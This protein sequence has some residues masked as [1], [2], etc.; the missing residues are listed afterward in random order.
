MG[1]FQSRANKCETSPD[2][3]KKFYIADINKTDS[4]DMEEFENL[5][6]LHTSM[7]PSWKE[8]KLFMMCDKNKNFIISRNEFLDFISYY[9]ECKDL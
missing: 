7:R 6:I 4:V 1:Q 9:K 2:T 3:Y 5:Y 8:W